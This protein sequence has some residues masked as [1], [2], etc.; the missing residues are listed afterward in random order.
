MRML[1]LLCALGALAGCGLQGGGAGRYVVGA[2]Y[3]VGGLWRYPAEDFSLTDTGIASVVSKGGAT[4]NGESFDAANLAASHRTLQLPAIARLTNLENGRQV[5][6]RINDR[7][8]A[9]PARL[10]GVTRTVAS[11]LGAANPSAFRVRLQVLEGESRQLAQEA[12]GQAP[13]APVRVEAAPRGGVQA[14]SLA[15]PGG[16]SEG[17]GRVGAAPIAVAQAAAAAPSAIPLRLAPQV[18]Q[19]SPRPGVLAIECGAFGST[20]AADMMRAT[21]ARHGAQMRA[22]YNA[23]RDRAVVV[24][25]GPLPSLPAAEARLRQVLG[26]GCPDGRI[27]V[28]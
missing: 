16:A 4:S 20:S 2:P 19:A 12:Q 23:P 13:A 5:V 9:D 14:E 1:L 8:P 6:V 26:A 15:P 7:G 21:L 10:L 18:T 11:L 25:I 24:R 27:I 28:E 17:R 3:Q 22:D